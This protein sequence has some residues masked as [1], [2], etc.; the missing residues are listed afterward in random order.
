MKCVLTLVGIILTSVTSILL[1]AL[2]PMHNVLQH[3][4]YWY[5]I[6]L[7][8]FILCTYNIFYFSILAAF[9]MNTAHPLKEKFL[10]M[11]CLIGNVE[12]ILFLSITYWIW[13]Q[14][15][16]F[17]YPIPHQIMLLVVA[18]QITFLIALWYNFPLDF[19]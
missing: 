5:E 16:H 4:D 9:W 12:F 19:V 18:F 10:G 1:I 15:F 3:P 11:M 13:T 14:M 8:G 2:I 17:N 7:H 6:I